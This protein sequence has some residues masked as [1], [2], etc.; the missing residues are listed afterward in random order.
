M[1][2]IT[3][4]WNPNIDLKKEQKKTWETLN[5]YCQK[6]L[7]NKSILFHHSSSKT[8]A[9]GKRKELI[10]FDESGKVKSTI[11]FEYPNDTTEVTLITNVGHEE[12]DIKIFNENGYLIEERN[13]SF[14]GGIDITQ[15]FYDESNRLIEIREKADGKSTRETFIYEEGRLRRIKTMVKGAGTVIREFIYDEE[16]KPLKIIRV[17]KGEVNL[18]ERYFYNEKGQKIKEITESINRLTGGKNSSFVKKYEYYANGQLKS[19]TFEIIDSLEGFTKSKT[20]ESFNEHGLLMELKG[21]DY[22]KK[23]AERY[24]YEYELFEM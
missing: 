3:Y 1:E 7:E 12:R 24:K 18:K 11:K 9:E 20:M 6:D 22:V 2:I 5:I 16:G 23:E 8:N 17:Q 15:Y 4:L 14:W 10:Y 13:S 21:I 19:E